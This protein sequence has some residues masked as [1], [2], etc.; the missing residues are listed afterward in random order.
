MS[1]TF[2]LHFFLHIFTL[3][4]HISKKICLKNYVIVFKK[5]DAN[6]YFIS[7]I[8]K[9]N[10]LIMNIHATTVN[11]T[12]LWYVLVVYM[13]YSLCIIYTNEII[14]RVYILHIFS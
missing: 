3:K 1:F 11:L 7:L 13:Y 12:T 4:K 8:T 14:C 9:I 6:T 2:R 5:L 10:Y